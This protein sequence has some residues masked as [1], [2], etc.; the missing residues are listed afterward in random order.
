VWRMAQRNYDPYPIPCNESA[1][2]TP[3]LPYVPAAA[4]TAS[5]S[6][7]S[8]PIDLSSG[9]CEIILLSFLDK[10]HHVNNAHGK[11]RARPFVCKLVF[12]PNLL[13]GFRQNLVWS[14][15]IKSWP[16][17]LICTSHLYDTF[18]HHI[19]T[20][21]FINSLSCEKMFVCFLRNGILYIQF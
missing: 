16:G 20:T 7:A 13:N 8:L 12:P 17:D 18:V 14:V 15:Y 5:Y 9:G 11:I 10:A 3:P 21:F 2:S 19:K 1:T 6:F 4:A